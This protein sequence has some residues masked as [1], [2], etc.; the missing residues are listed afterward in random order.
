MK[1]I[2]AI[3]I[4]IIVIIL[5]IP[6]IIILLMIDTSKP[7]V[8][9]YRENSSYSIENQ[10]STSV[11]TM[12]SDAEHENL[13]LE[14][15]QDEL[16]VFIYQQL[17][18]N[19][20]NYLI[21]DDPANKYFQQQE[22]TFG[23]PG[24][25]TKIHNDGMTIKL[26]ADLLSPIKFSSSVSL[27]FKLIFNVKD[28]P[29]TMQLIVTSAK[30]GNLP[31]PKNLV[32][33]IA[34]SAG[35]DIKG[36]IEKM[37]V[38]NGKRFGTFDQKSWTLSI[39]KLEFVE[40][41]VGQDN[42]AI[43]TLVKILTIN[44]LFDISI[45][46]QKAG[47][48]LTTTKLYSDKALYVVPELFKIRTE[49][50]KNLF[51]ASKSLDLM[52]SSLDAKA[53]DLYIKLTEV[54]LNRLLEY[55]MQEAEAMQQEIDLGGQKY[56]LLV[57]PPTIEI[58]K[59]GMLLNV[60]ISL[61]KD[62]DPSKRFVS[63]LQLVLIPSHEESDLVF[64]IGQLLIGDEVMLSAEE[65]D[66]LLKFFGGSEIFHSNMLIIN[67]FLLN[68]ATG[69]VKHKDTE[70][71]DG[72]LKL[73][74]TGKDASKTVIINDIHA[75]IRTV[76]GNAL[77]DHA[78][79]LTFY[80]SFKDKPKNELTTEV[81]ELMDMIAALPVAERDVVRGKLLAGMYFLVPG[82]ADLIPMTP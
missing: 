45:A 29:G 30:I 67:N 70:T 31:L 60:K 47:T 56:K 37:L 80:N 75:Q 81:G 64:E 6:I 38:S 73:T 52:L 33:S 55:Y 74:Y 1:K 66:D 57:S 20:P 11:D 23:L 9:V 44:E 17:L 36:E 5:L 4:S 25:W 78:E 27:R 26:R 59:E 3:I 49:E 39:D 53:D 21:D 43:I 46:N 19:S 15:S 61:E 35:F 10:L 58:K 41:M 22:G 51:L 76:T 72:Y 82:V 34:T 18:K 50:Q 16:N 69:E 14:L 79:I 24:V 13:L 71:F 40:A 48:S 32:N 2:F 62:G 8:S 42:A 7:P 28:D 12:L 54:D 68:F 63:T 65:T 77:S